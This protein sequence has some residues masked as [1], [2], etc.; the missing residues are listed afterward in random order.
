MKNLTSLSLKTEQG[1]LYVLD[2]TLLPQQQKW[3]QCHTVNDMVAM[4][5]ALQLRGAPAIGI[6]ACLLLAYRARV[7]DSREQLLLDAEVLR[8]ARPTAVNLMNN[9]DSMIAALQQNDFKTA[10]IDCAGQLFA[11]DVQLCLNMARHGAALV[12]QGEQ[13]LTHCNTGGL[14]TAGIG[15]ALGVINLAHQ[16]GKNIRLWVDETRPLLQGGRLTAW[17]CQQ[18]G[19]PYQ[20]IC[21]NMAAM[22]MARGQV[23]RIFVG[24]D[25][26]AANG[27]FANKV[28]TYSLAVLAHY[29]KVP[30][31][32]VA[33]HT[34]VDLA[35][36]DGSAIPI[37]QR[38]GDE[39]RGV[40]GAFGKAIWAPEDAV[41][42]NPAFDVT[43]AAL[44]TGWVLDTGV[45]SQ[46]DIAAGVL[47]QFA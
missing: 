32:V 9:L 30:F 18:L 28:G 38:H 5:K 21:D 37:E 42:F 22:L 20:L 36:R 27:D 8:A 7:G 13:L 39:V 47:K 11:E 29:H 44:V 24:S 10:A 43:P 19:I 26:I 35:C 2:Q 14:A 31:Y 40:S 1:K 16:Q 25:R 15:T 3:L 33:P 12:Q 4:I 23:D 34:T 45:Y 41:V 46:A 6:G 17:E